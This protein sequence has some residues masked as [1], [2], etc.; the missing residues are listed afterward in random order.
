MSYILDA[1]RKADAQ[2][3]RDPARGIHAQPV[4]A[5][6]R[7]DDRA[8]RRQRWL[9][10]VVAAGVALAG[11]AAW[12]LVATAPPVVVAAVA[13][14]PA[15]PVV[16]PLVVPVPA[17]PAAAVQPPPVAAAPVPAAA[18]AAAKAKAPAPA[19][20]LASPATSPDTTP[21]T[22]A[23]A[24]PAAGPSVALL[25]AVAA[26]GPEP[27]G[28]QRVYALGDLPA[29]IQRDLPKLAVSGG[30]YSNNPAQRMLVVNGQVVNEGAEAAAGVV[31]EQ[32]RARTAV[33][34]YRGYRYSLPF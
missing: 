22:S 2:R 10:G 5:V 28:G 1:L 34:R 23:A 8:G 21:A 20:A 24:L 29:E 15:R 16:P 7:T 13:I 3:E 17:G 12:R 4:L 26:P 14:E 19:S 27:A 32:I 25:P 30:V 31:L 9:W 6:P 11:W 18:P 33:F